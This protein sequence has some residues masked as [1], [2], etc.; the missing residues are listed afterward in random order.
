[1]TSPHLTFGQAFLANSPRSSLQRRR[2]RLLRMLQGLLRLLL[3]DVLSPLHH[4]VQELAYTVQ[5]DPVLQE[6]GHI[7]SSML[8]LG[9]DSRI[10]NA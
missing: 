8:G 5:A 6:L 3:L 1:M 4:T 9:F 10:A 2:H 7:I